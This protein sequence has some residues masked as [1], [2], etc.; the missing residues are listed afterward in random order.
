MALRLGAVARYLSQ[1]NFSPRITPDLR[2]PVRPEHMSEPVC[3]PGYVCDLPLLAPLC[4]HACVYVCVR[5]CVVVCV[6][7]CACVGLALA[8]SC[9][10]LHVRVSV[11]A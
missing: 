11:C 3:Q 8:G 4:L 1:V 7:E 9:V 5:V 10:C 2:V 6:R